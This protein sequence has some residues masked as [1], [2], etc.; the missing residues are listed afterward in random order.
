MPH[1]ADSSPVPYEETAR[2]RRYLSE[3]EVADSID[4]AMPMIAPHF[5]DN[6]IFICNLDGA[7]W[8]LGQILSRV[9]IDRSGQ[10]RRVKVT[11]ATGQARH[12]EPRVEQ[13]LANPEEINGVDVVV[14]EDINDGGHTLAKVC[15]LLEENEPKSITTIVLFDKQGVQKSYTPDIVVREIE[16]RYVFGSGLDDGTGFGRDFPGLYEVLS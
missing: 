14:P 11:S 8:F 15:Q 5:T 9:G 10:V 12:G 2:Y 1:A 7:E 13:W 6:A 16:N 4:R 3:Q